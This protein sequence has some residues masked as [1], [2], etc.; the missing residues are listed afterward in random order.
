MAAVR[1]RTGGAGREADPGFGSVLKSEWRKFL[2]TPANRTMLVLAF[3]LTVGVTVLT[4]GFGDSAALAREQAEGEYAVIFFAGG[5]GTLTFAALAG[6]T[7]ASEFRGP[8]VY[9]LTATPRRWRPL[10]AELVILAVLALVVGVAVAQVNFHVSQAALAVAG[11]PTLSLGAAGM[12]RAT[13]VYIPVGM[14]V[15]AVL[16]ACAAA[17]LRSAA[18]AF[19]LVFL[20]NALPVFAA[21]FLGEW[22]METV[23]R[24]TYGAAVESLAGIAVPGSEGYLPTA[25]AVLVVGAWLAVFI[26]VAVTVFE[27][28]DA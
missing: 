9:T 7:V 25:V 20:V 18:G 8:A 6:N 13:L 17:V 16:T 21:P 11:E 5:F 2:A 27:R 3:V 15:Q 19:V 28:R 14:A 10:L 22:W 23:P 1:E 4:M 26:A 12:V 24:F